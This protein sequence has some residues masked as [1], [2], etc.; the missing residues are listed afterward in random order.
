MLYI[1]ESRA[2]HLLSGENGQDALG[3]AER[4]LRTNRICGGAARKIA[5]KIGMRRRKN[6]PH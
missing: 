5:G 2:S 4:P 3:T 6:E 1:F